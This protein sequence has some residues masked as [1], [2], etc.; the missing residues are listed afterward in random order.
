MI[1]C[2][3]SLVVS[4]ITEEPAT[5]EAR[6]WFREHGEAGLCASLWTDTEVASGLA[7][8]QRAGKLDRVQHVALLVHWRRLMDSWRVLTVEAR[9]F[10]EA[11][12]L[13]ALGLRAGDALHLAIAADHRAAMATRDRELARAAA[14][15][16]LGVHELA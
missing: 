5:V 16:G 3:T 7:Q 8:K 15:L 12:D 11:A 14:S 1:Y 2:D 6:R 4:A 13:T 9:H 10:A